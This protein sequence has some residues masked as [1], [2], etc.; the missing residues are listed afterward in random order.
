MTSLNRDKGETTHRF[1]YF[2]PDGRRFLYCVGVRASR[3]VFAGSLDG[4]MPTVVLPDVYGAAYSP[5]GH[6]LFSRNNT[7]V[8]QAFDAGSLRLTG[9]PVTVLPDVGDASDQTGWS[10]SVAA[11]G[12]LAV[13]AA[14]P[15]LDVLTWF[16][17]AGKPGGVVGGPMEL[18]GCRQPARRAI[19][20]LRHLDTGRDNGKRPTPDLG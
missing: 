17:R 8:A 10:Y 9:A 6:L 20:P 16:D 2:L 15:H 11:S 13:T 19:R 12:A 18:A 5:T 4:T 3:S 1:P 14:R 7:L